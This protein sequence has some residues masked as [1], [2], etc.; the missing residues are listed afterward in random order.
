MTSRRGILAALGLAL[1]TL[2]TPA[3]GGTTDFGIEVT[4]GKLEVSIPGGSTYN[5]PITVRNSSTDSVHVQATMVDF[6]VGPSGEYQ[7][8][9]VGSRPYGLMKWASIKP[10]EFDIGA[11]GSQQVQLTIQMPQENLAGEYAGIV[12]FQTRPPRHGGNAIAFA[13]RIASKFYETIPGTVNLAGAITKMSAT[14]AARGETYRVQ[15]KNTGNAHVY[16]HGQLMVQQGN[17]VVDTIALATGELVERDGERLLEVHGK[18]LPPG[19]YQA[20]ATIDYGGKTETGGEIAFD[21]H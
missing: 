9:R 14:A 11:G 1:A 4:P 20:I 15:F 18:K 10:R 3:V 2:M 21:V 13:V 5:L 17:S 7:F 8:T 16:L 6:G 19:S 12:F